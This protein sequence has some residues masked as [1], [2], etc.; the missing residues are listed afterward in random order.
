MS[1]VTAHILLEDTKL[2]SVLA[3]QIQ[4][5][6]SKSDVLFLEASI[7]ALQRA[8]DELKMYMDSGASFNVDAYD[9]A[10]KEVEYLADCT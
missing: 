3:D 8:R 10:L 7:D 1:Q 2:D 5:A 9:R 4:R 6:P